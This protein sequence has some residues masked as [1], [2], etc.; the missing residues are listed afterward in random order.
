MINKLETIRQFW[1]ED[2]CFCGCGDPCSQLR[3]IQSILNNVYNFHSKKENNLEVDREFIGLY[4][5]ILNVL[6]NAGVIEHGTVITY[7]WLTEYGEQVRGIL[8]ELTDEQLN[9]AIIMID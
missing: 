2:L 9:D 3:L 6:D 8:N 5:F 1:Y 7:G 4:E